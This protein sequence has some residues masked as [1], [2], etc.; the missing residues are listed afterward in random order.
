MAIIL[1][2]LHAPFFIHSYNFYKVIY[3][4]KLT[5]KKC[6]NYLRTQNK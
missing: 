6:G 1:E 4:I 5:A 2:G 3:S